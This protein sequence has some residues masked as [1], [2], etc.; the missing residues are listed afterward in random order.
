MSASGVQAMDEDLTSSTSLSAPTTTTPVVQS[1]M[2]AELV[3]TGSGARCIE[4]TVRPSELEIKIAP[5]GVDHEKL[6]KALPF[7]SLR[8]S[9][10]LY[11]TTVTSP[12]VRSTL[13]MT[14][15]S[16][17]AEIDPET[18]APEEKKFVEKFDIQSKLSLL[19]TQE[20]LYRQGKA[21]SDLV[22]EDIN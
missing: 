22:A 21:L 9:T 19:Y 12:T 16:T 3:T 1:T 15:V 14:S 17:E 13:K 7:P 2:Q 8:S 20:C 10:G 6:C 11:A 5:P 18:L 4:A